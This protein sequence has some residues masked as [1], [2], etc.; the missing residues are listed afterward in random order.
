MSRAQGI[1]GLPDLLPLF[2]L[3]NLRLL[4]RSSR[5]TGVVKAT[6][7]ATVLTFAAAMRKARGARFTL[8]QSEPAGPFTG[9]AY[10]RAFAV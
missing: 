1:S 6:H 3:G 5:V 2:G 8:L 7:A 9:M 10:S 4:G